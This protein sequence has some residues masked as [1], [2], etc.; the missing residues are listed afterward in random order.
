[1]FLT[2]YYGVGNS[3]RSLAPHVAQVVSW[4]PYFICCYTLVA[5]INGFLMFTVA[6]ELIQHSITSDGVSCHSFSIVGWIFW[7]PCQPLSHKHYNKWG[8]VHLHVLFYSFVVFISYLIRLDVDAL[9]NVV[10]SISLGYRMRQNLAS[11]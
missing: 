11:N 7:V 10:F 6:V 5:F 2:V 8:L 3:F 4:I 1:L 9:L